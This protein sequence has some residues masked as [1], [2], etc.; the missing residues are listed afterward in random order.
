MDQLKRINIA[1]S[2]IIEE[3]F[4][5]AHL[6]D[7]RTGKY[8]QSSPGFA[9]KLGLESARDVIGLTVNDLITHPKHGAA[10][11]SAQA[12]CN[13]GGSSRKYLKTLIKKYRAQNSAPVRKPRFSLPKGTFW[14]RI[15]SKSRFFTTNIKQSSPSIPTVAIL[16]F[17]AACLNCSVCIRNFIRKSR[18]FSI[19]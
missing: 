3:T 8:I 11:T 13:G 17:N 15:R 1:L 16:L 5:I 4:D 2:D 6:K 19:Y 12:L 9:E 14:F 7:A 10:K 18:R